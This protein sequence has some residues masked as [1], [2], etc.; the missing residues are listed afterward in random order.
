MAPPL[1][2][3]ARS[4]FSS[5]GSRLTTAPGD[6][7]GVP[8]Y[9][10]GQRVK[11][12]G[13]A[14]VKRPLKQA[15]GGGVVHDHGRVRRSRGLGQPGQ[16]GDPQQRVGRRLGPQHRRCR[17]QLARHRGQVPQVDVDRDGAVRPQPVREHPGPVVAVGGQHDAVAALGQ[18]EHQRHRGG[19]PG[20]E[21]HRL[22]VL[23]AAERL[24]QRFPARVAVPAVAPFPPRLAL[25]HVDAG[26]HQ[27]RS[28]RRGRRH[29]GSPRGSAWPRRRRY[30]SCVFPGPVRQSPEK[31]YSTNCEHTGTISPRGQ[32]GKGNIGQRGSRCPQWP[33]G[34]GRSAPCGPRAG[35][36]ARRQPDHGR[37][38]LQ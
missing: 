37:R 3:Q 18:R 33:A 20:G 12:S 13:R 30:R 21:D 8:G 14:P 23:Q 36:P 34:P 1:L 11:R 35:R 9:R 16:V 26:R 19:L 10:L 4:P 5:S 27:R 29:G 17:L 6:H 7:V 22:R 31:C 15:G 38:G 32:Y 28:G 24:L 2:R 25:G